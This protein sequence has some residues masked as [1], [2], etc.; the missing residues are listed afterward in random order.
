MLRMLR[1]LP[2]LPVEINASSMGW[3]FSCHTMSTG[4]SPTITLQLILADSPKFEGSSPKSN[5]DIFGGTKIYMFGVQ[6]L[7]SITAELPPNVYVQLKGTYLNF[8]DICYI[9]VNYH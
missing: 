9:H 5:G 6:R 4:R 1:R 2:I 8:T 3:P 7:A